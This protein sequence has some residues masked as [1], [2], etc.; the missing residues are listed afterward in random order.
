MASYCPKEREAPPTTAWRVIFAFDKKV[1]KYNRDSYS[2][3]LTDGK[4]SAQEIDQVLSEIE[5]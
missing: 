1:E 5:D 2:P 3:Q 4:A